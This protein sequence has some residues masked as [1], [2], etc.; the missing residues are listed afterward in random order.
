MVFLENK[1]PSTKISNYTTS[2]TF[3]IIFFFKE[4]SYAFQGWI[5]LIKHS[6]NSQ[7]L[8]YY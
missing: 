8:K 7:I 2:Q 6:K 1:Q 5:Y 3:R 4:I